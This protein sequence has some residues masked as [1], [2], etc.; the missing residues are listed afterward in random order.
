MK[1]I[2]LNEREIIAVLREQFETKPRLPLGFEDDVASYPFVK[3]KELVVKTDMLVGGTDVPPGMTVRQAARKAV[4]ATVSDFAAKGVSPRILMIGLGLAPPVKLRTV[5]EI[6]H[7][8]GEAAREYGCRIIGGDTSETS[9]LIIDCIGIGLARNGR[10]IPRNGAKPGDVVAVTGDFGRTVAGFQIL[11]SK[12]KKEERKYPTLVRAVV[13][14]TAQ[15]HVGLGLAKTGYVNSSIDSSDGLA[16]SL[17]EIAR[18][19]RVNIVIEKVPIAK[20]AEEFA[21][22]HRLD[23]EKMALYGGEEY[24]LVLTISRDRFESVRN[25]VP[26]LRKIGRVEKGSGRV[27]L[28]KNAQLVSIEPRGYQHFR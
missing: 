3:T 27:S 2:G 23:S 18:L 21:K 19:G 6:A 17:S 28:V 13:H 20:T 24:E 11:I 1:R 5:R 4:V 22:E 9:D 14:P 25:R 16:W 15:L 8:L 26:G 12:S 7:G 10:V